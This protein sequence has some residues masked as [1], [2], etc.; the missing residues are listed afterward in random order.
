MLGL[1]KDPKTA[2]NTINFAIDLDLDYA[3]FTMTTRTKHGSLCGAAQYGMLLVDEDSSRNTQSEAV[4][5]NGYKNAHELQ[6][7]VSAPTGNFISGRLTGGRNLKPSD[8]FRCEP[9]LRRPQNR[10]GDGPL[11]NGK[12]EERYSEDMEAAVRSTSSNSDI[13]FRRL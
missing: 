6:E 1:R 9:P 5:P 8:P 7:T 3:Q 2:E 13:S 11:Q 4:H 10:A 12:L